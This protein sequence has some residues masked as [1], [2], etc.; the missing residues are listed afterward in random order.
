M[1][2]HIHH[3]WHG[4][5]AD[6]IGQEFG[7]L[8][9][10]SR[11]GSSNGNATWFCRCECLGS[12]ITTTH[13]LLSG[14]VRSCGCLQREH[15]KR[16]GSHIMTTHPKWRGKLL[17]LPCYED[18]PEAVAD[19]SPGR[20]PWKTYDVV[21]KPDPKLLKLKRKPG[22]P[23]L[24]AAE[25][26]RREAAKKPPG[27]PCQDPGKQVL[28]ECFWRISQAA[29]AAGIDPAEIGR[30]SSPKQRQLQKVKAFDDCGKT[31]VPTQA[32]PSPTQIKPVVS[33]PR[34]RR[35]VLLKEQ[36]E[37]WERLP[38]GEREA[39]IWERARAA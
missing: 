7:R 27:R 1:T 14:N 6:L 29:R 36:R 30:A 23:R 8:V 24:P 19:H 15:A 13:K 17:P 28:R 37:G 5:S 34:R 35:K 31:A 32:A 4:N 11:A 18:D 26:E 33:M 21:F 16:H 38:W 20:V 10:V 12:T 25:L 22:R 39:A 2:E 9:V 3:R